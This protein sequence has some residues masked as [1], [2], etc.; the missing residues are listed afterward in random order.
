MWTC[1]KYLLISYGKYWT[2]LK[3]FGFFFIFACFFCHF[4]D[5]GL[6]LNGNDNDDDQIDDDDKDDD[7]NDNDGMVYFCISGLSLRWIVNVV[8]I[9]NTVV[10]SKDM[11]AIAIRT[12]NGPKKLSPRKSWPLEIGV[13]FLTTRNTSHYTWL[14]WIKSK[15]QNVSI[16]LKCHPFH[17]R[18]WKKELWLIWMNF[19]FVCFYV[20]VS[21]CMCV[22]VHMDSY[23]LM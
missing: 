5:I 8:R 12:G 1:N 22:C 15:C 9:C 2:L 16:W 7:D 17:F 4:V 18:I 3:S 19:V 23:K 14:R 13:I 6:C 11:T 21:V 20:S 10:P